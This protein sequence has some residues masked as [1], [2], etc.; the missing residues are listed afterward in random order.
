HPD[1]LEDLASA[2]GSK[3]R[4]GSIPEA[5]A[6]AEVVVLAVPGGA[7]VA[8]AQGLD[9]LDGRI[10]VDATNQYGAND[11]TPQLAGAL[12]RASAVKAFNTLAAALLAEIDQRS[13][14]DRLVLFTCGNHSEAT[15][16]VDRLI[17]DA[18]GV[19]HDLGDLEQAPLMSPGG[20]LYNREVTSGTLVS[21]LEGVQD[22]D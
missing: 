16:V 2:A 22:G 3:A 7:A 4:T 6:F 15:A 1:N 11:S 10:L 21:V 14:D 5:G 8:T 13:G 19:P 12:P 9:G 20:P 18:G 17:E